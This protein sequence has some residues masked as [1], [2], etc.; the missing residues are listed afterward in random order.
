VDS[1][2]GIHGGFHWLQAG[3]RSPGY[4]PRSPPTK[5]LFYLANLTFCRWLPEGVASQKKRSDAGDMPRLAPPYTFTARKEPENNGLGAG[6]RFGLWGPPRHPS[7]DH[8]RWRSSARASPEYIQ[9]IPSGAGLCPFEKCPA[10]TFLPG[11]IP[12]AAPA[13]LITSCFDR[14]RLNRR[15][16]RRSE[17]TDSP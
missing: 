15:L 2:C 1:G 8:L 10:D 14:L 7:G 3:L 4:P 11:T 6:P 16:L 9:F 5:C 17:I 12:Y 13:S